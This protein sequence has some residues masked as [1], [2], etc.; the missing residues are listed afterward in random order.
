VKGNVLIPFGT[1]VLSFLAVEGI[2]SPHSATRSKDVRSF[3]DN[4]KEG[5][6]IKKF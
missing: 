1:V 4:L 5:I 6:S 2:G 3:T